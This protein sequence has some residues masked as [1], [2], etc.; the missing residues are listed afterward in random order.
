MS[1][2]PASDS[3]D[4]E[5]P[6]TLFG[7]YSVARVAKAAGVTRATFY[8][9]WPSAADYM[10]DL[11]GHLADLDPDQFTDDVE[12][13]VRRVEIASHELA[14]PFLAGCDAQLRSVIDDPALPIRLGFLSKMHDP[15]VA[16]QLRDRYRKL[17][18]RQW[19][20]PSRMLKSWGRELRPPIEPF[21]LV[22]VH[23]GLQESLA[24][25]H[26][27]DPE[28]VPV[29]IYGYISLVLL[30]LLTR[31]VDDPRTVDDI[32]GVADTWPAIGLQLLAQQAREAPSTRQSLEPEMV[33]EMTVMAR[34]IL[35]SIAVGGPPHGRRGPVD[36]LQRGALHPCLPHQGRARG[37]HRH[38]VDVRA[39]TTR[40][41]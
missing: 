38:P 4:E 19:Q 35:A 32:L 3:G 12:P 21:Q 5:A 20:A 9:Y 13:V 1:S 22:A 11:L 25:R 29:E 23:S 16:S 31:H 10:D 39:C 40:C 17:E 15:A 2:T 28:A 37:R 33:R 41:R 27:I 24:A 34:S 36:R 8:S 18:D 14:T 30:L 7:G 26:I 6:A